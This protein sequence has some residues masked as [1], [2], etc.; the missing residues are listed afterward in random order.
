VEEGWAQGFSGRVIRSSSLWNVF[1]SLRFLYPL[2]PGSEFDATKQDNG[3]C[4]K[5]IVPRFST[6]A[7]HGMQFGG[8]VSDSPA[9]GG[10]NGARGGEGE[11]R[12]VRVRCS[13]RSRSC[14]QECEGIDRWDRTREISAEKSPLVTLSTLDRGFSGRARI[15]RVSTGLF[16]FEVRW[17]GSSGPLLLRSSGEVGCV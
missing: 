17:S 11:K 12:V 1:V 10:C 16:E 14:K 3:C 9:K 8:V 7:Q 13:R 6:I 2:S 5:Q 4:S 15:G